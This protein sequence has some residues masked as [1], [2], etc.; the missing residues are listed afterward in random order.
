MQLPGIGS[1][2][3]AGAAD[4]RRVGS[5]SRSAC[6]VG[7]CRS[8]ARCCR[9]DRRSTVSILEMVPVLC[10]R[11]HILASQLAITS[12]SNT[13]LFWLF[14]SSSTTSRVPAAL[15]SLSVHGFELLPS[16]RVLCITSSVYRLFENIFRKISFFRLAVKI[17]TSI[18][19]PSMCST[20]SCGGGVGVVGVSSSSRSGSRTPGPLLS[21]SSSGC[22]Q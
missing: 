3:G 16:L 4:R 2:T 14:V 8:C 11:V 17:M 19:S 20:S 7:S 10:T 5:R 9:S 6:P 18:Q 12:K 22:K 1:R 15:C 21:V 13:W